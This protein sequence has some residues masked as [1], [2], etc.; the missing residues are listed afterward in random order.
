LHKA[1]CLIA[2]K[3]VPKQEAEDIVQQTYRGIR[4]GARAWDPAKDPDFAIFA[5]MVVV[6]NARNW[7]A[8]SFNKHR[9]RGSFDAT[10][11]ARI[12]S[13]GASPEALAIAK[14]EF[15]LAFDKAFPKGSIEH[16]LFALVRRGITDVHEQA[17][18]LGVGVE[19][20]RQLIARIHTV[21]NGIIQKE[22]T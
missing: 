15:T 7:R 19:R 12:A 5:G 9:D 17:R 22:R 2:A 16:A 1:L 10:D 18:A 4:S 20:I 14:Q 13:V 11:Q 8:I 3:H 21:C 6:S